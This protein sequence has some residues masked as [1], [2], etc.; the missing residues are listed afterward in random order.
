MQFLTTLPSTYGVP[1]MM[2]R[3][4]LRCY[5]AEAERN[6]EHQSRVN[7]LCQY[8]VTAWAD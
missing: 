4:L 7:E 5:Q 3:P 2:G 8:S 6:S 1:H